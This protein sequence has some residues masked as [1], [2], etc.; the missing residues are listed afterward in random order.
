MHIKYE[1]E[2]ME[3]W[4]KITLIGVILI[5]LAAAFAV[6]KRELSIWI[7]LVIIVAVLDIAVGILRK[8]K[9]I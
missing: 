2:T 1:S 7:I 4:K 3:E 8:I 9:G 6:V 5:I